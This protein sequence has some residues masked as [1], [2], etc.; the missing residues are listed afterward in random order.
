MNVKKI[1]H[2]AQIFHRVAGQALRATPVI[3]AG[4]K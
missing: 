4:V 1:F 3:T 2:R